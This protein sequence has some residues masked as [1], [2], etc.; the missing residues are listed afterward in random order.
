MIGLREKDPDRYFATLLA[1]APRRAPLAL[2]FL[3]NHELARAVEVA[4]EPPLALMRLQWWRELAE[5]APRA[6]ELAAPLTAAL[7]RGLFSREALLG[8][9]GARETQAEGL[10]PEEVAG[11]A[12]ASGGALARMAGQVLGGDH[13][14]LEELGTAQALVGLVRNAEHRRARRAEPRPEDFAPREA[15]LAEAARLLATHPPGGVVAAWG[16]AVFARRDLARLRAGQP[17]PAR[18]GAGD[19]LAVL[20]AALTRRV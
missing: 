10:A 2:L 15:L 3:V 18:R 1:P 13:P 5:G 4:S 19:R 7:A 20:V 14:A 16:A 9:I 11:F 8:L 17:C 12:R 6:H